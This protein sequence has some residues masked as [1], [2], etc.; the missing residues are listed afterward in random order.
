MVAIFSGQIQPE[1]YGGKISISIE[2]VAL[3]HFSTMHQNSPFLSSGNLSPHDV[4]HSFLSYDK[5]QDASTTAS[6]SKCIIKF[7]KKDNFFSDLR[8]ILENIDGCAKK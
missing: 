5:N 7:L 8:T 1:Y 4:F 2:G 6:H 3:Y